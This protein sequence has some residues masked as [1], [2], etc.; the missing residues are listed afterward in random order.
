MDAI[1][2]MQLLQF[3]IETKATNKAFVW[4]IIC[5]LASAILTL[6]IYIS[7]THKESVSK[8]GKAHAE[9]LQGI[10]KIYE[11][12]LKEYKLLNEKSTTALMQNTLETKLLTQSI[13]NLSR[14]LREKLS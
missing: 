11:E 14:L 13:D 7:K 4:V 6:V 8:L 3:E 1:F 2:I 10:Q 9:H 5:A 12:Q